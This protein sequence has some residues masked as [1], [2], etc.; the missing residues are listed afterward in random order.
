[1]SLSFNNSQRHFYKVIDEKLFYVQEADSIEKSRLDFLTTGA[2]FK[3]TDSILL[4]HFKVP[5]ITDEEDYR[6]GKIDDFD[7]IFTQFEEDNHH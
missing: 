4:V 6:A 3:L 1:M 7:K 5:A 2:T